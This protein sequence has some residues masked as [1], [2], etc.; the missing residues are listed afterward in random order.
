MPLH[1]YRQMNVQQQNA[2]TEE[3]IRREA[4][5]W[6]KNVMPE[7]LRSC[8]VDRG[9]VWERSIVVD[10]DIDFPGMP[11]LFGLLV[12][13]DELFVYFEIDTDEGHNVATLVERWENV[14]AA[15]I[16]NLHNRGVGAGRGALAIKVL[17]ELNV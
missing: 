14:S 13:Q 1:F 6:R 16:L 8:G 11:A 17:R 15:Q 2:Q 7:A 9:I 4:T 10:L 5:H 12:T 3:S